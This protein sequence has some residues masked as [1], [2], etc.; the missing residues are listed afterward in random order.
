MTRIC[1]GNEKNELIECN[2]EFCGEY[3]SKRNYVNFKCFRVR[4]YRH[5]GELLKGVD[6]ECHPNREVYA[7]FDGDM[8]FWRPYGNHE[9]YQCA[10]E[11]ARIE[12][13]GQW[14]GKFACTRY[15]VLIA[16]VQLDFFGGRVEKGQRIGVAK[17]HRCA[18]T[19]DDGEPYVR[20]QLF[21][22]G[23]PIDPTYHLR[24]C[25]CTGQICESNP[26]NEL[27]GKPFK[28]DSRYNGVR[29]WDIKCP[30]IQDKNDEEESRVPD[31]YS[32]IDA[33]VIGRSRLYAIQGVY[34]GCDN[35]GVVLVGTGAWS[36]YEVVLYNVRYRDRLLGRQH[37]VQGE[38]I[39]TRLNCEDSPDSVFMEVRYRGV[40][41][42]ISDMISAKTCRMP[43][44]P[45]K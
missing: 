4:N 23:R 40:V 20:L 44:F 2:G 32:P 18:Y 11:G 1:Q 31:I 42:D 14:Q 27:L 29:G 22:Q 35:N 21:R 34:T 12:G 43:E 41:V 6:I 16:S 5:D 24:D 8:Y 10:D 3:M 26:K 7:P 33:E 37:V 9:N 17:D 30:K 39:A 15:Y 38:P 19:D 28:H 13:I 36:D 25:M 45:P